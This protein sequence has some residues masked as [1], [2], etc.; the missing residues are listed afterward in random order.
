MGVDKV[1]AER[2]G[3]AIILLGVRPL[4][5]QFERRA[6]IE[7]GQRRIRRAFQDLFELQQRFVETPER[8]QSAPEIVASLNISGV[9]RHGA[10]EAGYGI[11]KRSIG[12]KNDAAVV[13]RLGKIRIE[14]HGPSEQRRRIG[15]SELMGHHPPELEYPPVVWIPIP[16]DPVEP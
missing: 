5:G 10:L 8:T 15:P 2:N 12:S 6:K 1:G 9:K 7:M 13:V 16:T 3:A 14:G 11:G 4:P